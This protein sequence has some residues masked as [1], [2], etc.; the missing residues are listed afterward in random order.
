MSRLISLN[1]DVN[2]RKPTQFQDLVKIGDDLSLSIT[3]FNGSNS[4]DFTNES[5]SV[6]LKKA[7]NTKVQQ[8]LTISGNVVSCATLDAQAST[9]VGQVEGE[10]TITDTGGQVTSSTFIYEVEGSISDEALTASADSIETLQQ[11]QT[12]IDTYNENAS[13]LATQNTQTLSNISTLGINNDTANTNI[14]NLTNVN[15]IASSNISS[16]STQNVTA[17]NNISSLNT[18]NSNASTNIAN[19]TNVNATATSNISS[20]NTQNSN[21]STNITNLTNVNNT[22]SNNISAIQSFNYTQV[23]GVTDDTGT[24]NAYVITLSNAPTAYAKYQTFKFIAK[25]ANTGSSTL[26]VNGLGVKLLVKDVNIV[27]VTGDILAGQIITAVYDGTNFQIIPDY[28]TQLSQL[29]KQNLLINGDFQVWQRGASFTPASTATYTADRW[30]CATL[31]NTLTIAQISTGGLSI[32]NSTAFTNNARF[33]QFIEIPASLQGKT[34]T[35]SINLSSTVAQSVMLFGASYNGTTITP[36]STKSISLTTTAT[37]YTLTF[38]APTT[39]YLY[40]GL[41]LACA[42]SGYY[43]STGAMTLSACTINAYWA[44]VEVGSYATSFVPNLYGEELLLCQRYYDVS[45]FKGIA[46]ATNNLLVE[47]AYSIFKRIT[48]TL[49]IKSMFAG[50]LGKISNLN[51]CTDVTFTVSSLNNNYIELMNIVSSDSNLVVGNTYGLIVYS[52]AEIY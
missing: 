20:L 9:Y 34:V 44:K 36:I 10:L 2:S 51:I 30:H 35:L 26:N 17:A 14:A 23:V 46:C 3:V 48:P 27:L 4:Y 49:T 22:A 39:S 41:A 28:S 47:Q 18:Q 42:S 50:A 40:I 6:F 5:V 25:T 38:N 13:N 15:N 7:D 43:G 24:A 11:V 19:L 29:T 32:T 12:L 52:D 45:C 31:N 8:T 37:T 33:G 16:L 21:A 1:L